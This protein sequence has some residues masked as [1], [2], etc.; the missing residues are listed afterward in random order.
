MHL[1]R[2]TYRLSSQLELRELLLDVFSRRWTARAVVQ[3]VI[4]HEFPREQLPEMKRGSWSA[5]QVLAQFGITELTCTYS[6]EVGL[7]WTGF[8]TENGIIFKRPENRRS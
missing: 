7:S 5:D 3:T 8:V 4:Q 6:N 2:L 1:F